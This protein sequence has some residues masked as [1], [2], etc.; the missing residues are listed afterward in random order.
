MLPGALKV[1]IPKLRTDDGRSTTPEQAVST[2][3]VRYLPFG[4]SARRV[5][6][7]PGEG[8]TKTSSELEASTDLKLSRERNV[9][10]TDNIDVDDGGDAAVCAVVFVVVVAVVPSLELAT[11]PSFRALKSLCTNSS[12]SKASSVPIPR[13]LS[14][15]FNSFTL[16]AFISLSIASSSSLP[17]ENN[18]ILLLYGALQKCT[19]MLQFLLPTNDADTVRGVARFE[20]GT[21]GNNEKALTSRQ[22]LNALNVI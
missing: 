5:A 18:D 13:D 20:R 8:R 19:L 11:L 17:D 10:G 14:S 15:T 3:N 21:V 6:N 9:R 12:F 4:K 16:I 22:T 7:C 2:S 1:G